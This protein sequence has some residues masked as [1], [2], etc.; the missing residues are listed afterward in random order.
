MKIILFLVFSSSC[1]ANL[2]TIEK[3]KNINIDYLESQLNTINA[4]EDKKIAIYQY[5]PTISLFASTFESA[6]SFGID[7]DQIRSEGITANWTVF[8]FFQDLYAYNY[9]KNNL[10]SN[11]AFQRAMELAAEKSSFEVFLNYLNNFEQY[12]VKKEITETL[13]QSAQVAKRG[14]KRGETSGSASSKILIQSMNTRNESETFLAQS[15]FF[16]QRILELLKIKTLD[17]IW[18]L[19]NNEIDKNIPKLL[20]ATVLLDKNPTLEKF[21]M[22]RDAI[23]DLVKS[24]QLRHLGEVNLNYR[25]QKSNLDNYNEWETQVTL[26]YSFPLFANNTIQR[27]V[28]K[29]KNNQRLISTRLKQE[30]AKLRAL[31]K[32]LKISM[33]TNF[34]NYKRNLDASKLANKVYKQ[35]LKKFRRGLVNVNDLL[36]EQQRQSQAQLGYIIAKRNLI[37]TLVDYCHIQGNS[38]KKC[39]Q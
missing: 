11:K 1:F 26:T 24:R 9:Q 23:N 13:D 36:F 21:R 38:F 7:V 19:T 28:V 12:K 34:E 29:A 30:K 3:L 22:D 6:A 17:N 5:F 32:S 31:K 15:E 37:L 39:L 18:P 14:F 10:K 27:D 4:N 25:K 2:V 33:R 20:N 35:E 16:K 8:N